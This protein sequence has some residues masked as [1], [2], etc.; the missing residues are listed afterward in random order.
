MSKF[1]I[2]FFAPLPWAELQQHGYRKTAGFMFQQFRERSEIERL[3]YVQQDRR[4]GVQ[5]EDWRVDDKVEVVGLPIGLPYER[6]DIIRGINRRLQANLLQSHLKGDLIYWFYDWL[7]IE[8]IRHLPPALTVMELTDSFY[9]FHKRSPKLLRRFSRLREDVKRLVDVHF[10]V[11]ELLVD[12][13]NDGSGR[14]EVMPNG[15]S[16]TFLELAGKSHPE[17]EELR[18]IAH[19]RLMVI[20]TQWSLNYRVDHQLLQ[21][22]LSHLPDWQLILIGCEEVISAGLKELISLP[23]THLLGMLAQEQLVA[24]IQHADVCTVPYVQEAEP[25]RDALKTYEYLACGKPVVVSVD[26]V[27]PAL[28]QFVW[29]G[30]RVETFVDACRRLIDDK[31]IDFERARSILRGMTWQKRADKC[32]E[33]V[34]TIKE[35]DDAVK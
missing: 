25:K 21:E 29:R 17:P 11:N 35:N 12:E 5:V 3:W 32:L 7:H 23:Q 28:E 34:K 1:H 14:V 20:G 8:L 33:I 18:G 19:P 16:E 30:D 2:V 24:F 10:V 9:Q 6:F 13:V 26:R 4:W 22:V 31:T 15:I 27:M